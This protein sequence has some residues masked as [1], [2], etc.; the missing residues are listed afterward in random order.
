MP[1]PVEAGRQAYLK[2][3][4]KNRQLALKKQLLI[5][6]KVRA[7]SKTERTEGITIM[8]PTENGLEEW[9]E[10]SK[11]LGSQIKSIRQV[12]DVSQPLVKSVTLKRN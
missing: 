1:V 4:F 12:T 3:D 5:D 8:V 10:Q 6:G 9:L 11:R 2:S 7:I